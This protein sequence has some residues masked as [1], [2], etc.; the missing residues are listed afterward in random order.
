MAP[1]EDDVR[2]DQPPPGDPGEQAGEGR[3]EPD[4]WGL[5]PVDVERNLS[6]PG[7][8]SRPP[9]TPQPG[10]GA[11]PFSPLTS[12]SAS[13]RPGWLSRLPRP[14][15]APC[16]VVTTPHQVYAAGPTSLNC[17]CV[18]GPARQRGR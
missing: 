1:D 12:G 6:D 9:G 10:P 17:L 4:D 7:W 18:P 16:P 14:R 11:W 5:T 3:P 15:P 8:P 13:C 2:A